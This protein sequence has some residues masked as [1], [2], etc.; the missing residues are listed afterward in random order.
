MRKTI[1]SGRHAHPLH[2]CPAPATFLPP[3]ITPFPG[4]QASAER[5]GSAYYLG[6]D[7]RGDGDLPRGP[8]R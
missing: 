1:G 2:R 8:Q 6:G 5:S 7:C 4:S 3:S